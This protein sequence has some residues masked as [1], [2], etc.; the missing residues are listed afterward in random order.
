M[1]YQRVAQVHHNGCFIAATAVLLGK[2]YE[3]TLK[4]IHPTKTMQDYDIGLVSTIGNE[5]KLAHDTLTR[6]GIKIRP[7]KE[8]RLRCLRQN[9]FLV[10]RWKHAP[11]LLHMVVYLAKERKF[12]DSWFEGPLKLEVYQRQL[13][14]V[15][16]IDSP[17]PENPATSYL[18][19]PS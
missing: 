15:F 12:L 8:R 5:A 10:I 16:L 3:D 2:S 14:A 13:D 6:L 17:P 19:D 4:L 11:D 1:P 9:A 7:T 18:P